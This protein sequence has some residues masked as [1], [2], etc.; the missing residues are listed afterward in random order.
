[1]KRFR[2]SEMKEKNKVFCQDLNRK[3]SKEKILH[4][5]VMTMMEIKSK[6]G[7]RKEEVRRKMTEGCDLYELIL[8]LLHNL[9][10]IIN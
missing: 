9:Y 4:Q 5:V 10:E 7:N 3:N 2:K 6:G 1:M 8:I